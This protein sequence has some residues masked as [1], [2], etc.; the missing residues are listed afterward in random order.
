MGC[1][2]SRETNYEPCHSKDISVLYP[3]GLPQKLPQLIA[4]AKELGI[5]ELKQLQDDR[6]S[7]QLSYVELLDRENNWQAM[8][9]NDIC[10]VEKI[11]GSKFHPSFPVTKITI[12]FETV[13]PLQILIDQLNEPTKRIKWDNNFTQINI[14]EGNYIEDFICQQK[15]KIFMYKGEYL[16][17]KVTTYQ[18]DSVIIFSYS[19]DHPQY[20]PIKGY[21]RGYIL[22]GVTY[23]KVENGLSKV[24][25]YNQIDPNCKIASLTTSIGVK[26]LKLWAKKYYKSVTRV[27][28]NTK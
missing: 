21:T 15:L 2:H 19:I 26:Q 4:Q 22:L 16:E 9:S 3:K 17:R 1:C 20:T 6:I 12:K 7:D 18:G 24:V 25:V 14:L 28:S 27:A 8:D 23:I 10:S 11:C 13:V 5:K